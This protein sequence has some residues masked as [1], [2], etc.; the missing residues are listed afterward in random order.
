MDTITLRRLAPKS[1]WDYGKYKGF[2][3]K[4]IMISEPKYLLWAYYSLERIS[5]IDEILDELANK[6]KKFKRIDKPG[7]DPDYFTDNLSFEYKKMSKKE[8]FN[9]IA[10]NRMN[11]RKSSKAL[12]AAYRIAKSRVVHANRNERISKSSLQA[13]NHGNASYMLSKSIPKKK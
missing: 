2:T 11:G 9:L 10:A 7:V 6:Y 3:V 4:D 13:I 12:L 8:L 1:I 5:F